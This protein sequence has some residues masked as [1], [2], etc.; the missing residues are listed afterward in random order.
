[1]ITVTLS[2]TPLQ[3]NTL[4]TALSH[5]ADEVHACDGMA[6]GY[7]YFGDDGDETVTLEQA[8]IALA[9]LCEMLTPYVDAHL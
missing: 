6:T 8:D 1:M 4:I 5:E 3:L 9:E 7:G 2:L